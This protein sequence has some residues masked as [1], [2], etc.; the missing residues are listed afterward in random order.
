MDLTIKTT[1]NQELL[2][3]PGVSPGDYYNL[4]GSES[5]YSETEHGNIY[6][7]EKQAGPFTIRLSLLQFIKKCTLYFRSH[8]PRSGVRIALENRWNVGLLSGETVTLRENQFVL[9]SPGIR[10][11]KMVFE[12]DQQYRGIEILCDP[13]KM[14]DL[15]DLFPGIAEYVGDG[16]ENSIFLQKK[17]VWAPDRALDMVKELVGL[18]TD[19]NLFILMNF[20]LMQVEHVMEERLPT[21]DEIEAAGR[22]EKLILKDIKVHHGIPSIANK[23]KLNENRLKYVFRH[24]FKKSIYQYLLG[25]RMTKAKFLLQHTDAPMEEIARDC[26]YRYLTSFITTFRKYYGY[27][28]RSVRRIEH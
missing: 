7:Q 12:K 2:F 28:P 23:V 26:G 15:M 18:N 16:E 9:F 24:V 20:L 17:P 1:N 21:I 25:A 3:I 5:W 13:S 14:D 8:T 6:F 10:G 11:E 22:A 19:D 4:P 27:T